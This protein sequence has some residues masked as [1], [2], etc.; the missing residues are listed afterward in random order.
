MRTELPLDALE[1]A[2][3]QRRIK[4]DSGLMHHSDLG[5]QYVSVRWTDR[6]ADI[7]A[8]ASAGS[9]A[10]S[11]DNAMAEALNGIFKTELIEAVS[12]S[13]LCLVRLARDRLRSDHTPSTGLRSGAYGGSWQ[14]VSRIRAA[15]AGHAYPAPVTERVVERVW[16][17]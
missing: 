16:R 3:W 1:M 4:K 7:G 2:L 13:R 5:A 17:A 8:S 6:L 14:T 11:Y 12:W 15:T 9:V 10:D